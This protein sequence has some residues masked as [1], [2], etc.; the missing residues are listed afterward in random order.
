[1]TD[2]LQWLNNNPIVLILL[3][4]IVAAVVLMYLVA[5][6]QGREVSFWPPK[7]G[8]KTNTSD[9]DFGKQNKMLSQSG[10]LRDRSQLMSVEQMAQDAVEISAMG[11]TLVSLVSTRVDF[12]AEK[13]RNGCN[14]RFLI[15]DP[16]S[17][18]MEVWKLSESISTPE[19]TV[20]VLKYLDALSRIE[21]AK[22]KCEVRLANIYLPFGL[23][24]TKKKKI[25]GAMNV[26]FLARNTSIANRPHF[27]LLEQENEKWFDFF[28]DQFEALW[29]KSSPRKVSAK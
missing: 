9:V 12:F 15:L 5:F 27:H 20:T 16:K 17:K 14:L 28:H 11:I 3:A 22:G 4:V 21:N 26:E 7:I 25:G 6:L 19:D 8:S 24:F 18:A 13:L 10:I 23:V 2:F 29:Q 1:M